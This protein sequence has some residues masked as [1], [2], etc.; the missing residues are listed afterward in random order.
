MND[1]SPAARELVESHRTDRMLTHADRARIKQKL[2]LRVST[3]TA[4]TAVA[5]TAAGMSLASKVI[6]VAL[7]VTGAVGGGSFSMWAMRSRAASHLTPTATSMQ[8]ATDL[9]GPGSDPASAPVV[10]VAAP[11]IAPGSGRVAMP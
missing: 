5:G 6:L 4:T 11:A 9:V 10:A 2:M 7:G 1:L 3:V 8:R